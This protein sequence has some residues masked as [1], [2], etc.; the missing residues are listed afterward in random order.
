MTTLGAWIANELTCLPPTFYLLSFSR[1][2][3]SLTGFIARVSALSHFFCLIHAGH[4][5]RRAW[6]RRRPRRLGDETG[7]N[8]QAFV[9]SFLQRPAFINAFANQSHEAF[10]DTLLGHSG[11]RFTTS[12]REVFVSALTDGTLSRATVLRRIAEDDHFVAANRSETFVMMQYFGYLR[13]DPDESGYQFWLNKLN[14]FGGDFERAE[15]TKAFLDS[16]EYRA[17]F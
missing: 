17:R 13:R 2:A 14:K 8:K 9:E 12:E 3:D 11:V 16:I 1:P 15:M 4:R 10:A 7:R 6:R 5:R